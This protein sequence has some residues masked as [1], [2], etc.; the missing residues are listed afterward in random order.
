MGTIGAR[1]G[2]N[3]PVERTHPEPLPALLEPNPRLVS[4]ELLTRTEF[5]P[6]TIVNVLAGAWLQFEV[7]DWF[8]HGK[9]VEE[10]PFELELADDDDWPDR[11][12]RIQRTR[13]DASHPGDGSPPTY[14]TA[15]SPLVGR[16]PDL[17]QRRGIRERASREGG[18][19]AP[20]RP[21]RP[22]SARPRVARR[23]HRRRRQLL[24]R[25]RAPAHALHP[26]AQRDLR[27]PRRG[28]AGLVRRRPLRPTPA[29]S[30][31]P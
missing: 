19:Q 26:R 21:R 29:S 23:P 17:R 24:A 14:V 30:M 20:P 2:R 22:A 28:A 16:L 27:P 7:H 13:P 11:P 3:V 1:F 9:N 6:A 12:M 5:K 10:A 4:R 31:P 8:S 25:A 18:R 15:D